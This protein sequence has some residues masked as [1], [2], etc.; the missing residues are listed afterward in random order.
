MVRLFLVFSI[1]SGIVF[2]RYPAVA[3]E[4]PPDLAVQCYDFQSPTRYQTLREE[5]GPVLYRNGQRIPLDDGRLYFV[6]PLGTGYFAY[7]KIGKEI[8]YL[9]GPDELYW[10]RPS[11]SYPVSDPE[12]KWILLLSGDLTAV[13]VM[14]HNGNAAPG[15]PLSGLL[16][17]DYAFS[18]DWQTGEASGTAA[19]VLFASG[20]LYIVRF[21]PDYRVFTLS[22]PD[23]EQ[24]FAKSVAIGKSRI[25]LHL[26]QGEGDFIRQYELDEE[27]EAL[28]P[29]DSTQLPVILP[30]RIPMA[31]TESGLVFASDRM[32]GQVRDGQLVWVGDENGFRSEAPRFDRFTVAFQGD[33][34]RSGGL[35]ATGGRG[36]LYLLSGD[37]PVALSLRRGM[38]YRFLFDEEGIAHEDDGGY[39]TIRPSLSR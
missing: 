22:I 38:P 10:R 2:Y 30:H 8:A 23:F 13:R 25:A 35:T 21:E 26:Q 15:Q 24:A 32:V 12:G 27:K 17:T 29:I 9:A 37:D 39:C 20:P 5:D 1:L 28:I 31:F 14:D 6:P 36:F 33:A 16:L 7:Q 34:F 18:P 3:Y 11:A 4:A 19:T